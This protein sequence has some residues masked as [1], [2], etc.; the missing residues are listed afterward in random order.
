MLVTVD[1]DKRTQILLFS[2]LYSFVHSWDFDFR[3]NLQGVCNLNRILNGNYEETDAI[4]D[5]TPD[6]QALAHE[7][8]ADSAQKTN[9]MRFTSEKPLESVTPFGTRKNK[10][11]VQLTLNEPPNMQTIKVEE[12]NANSEDEII[13]RV[14][15]SKKCSLEINKSQPEP[16]CRFM[17]DR[18][19]DKV[20]M[21]LITSIIVV[22]FGKKESNL[23]SLGSV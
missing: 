17:Y 10:Y 4:L 16:G 20:L 14:Q 11:V 12:D 21:S 8:S 18:I 5:T 19:E 15:P 13:K 6:K 1:L 3:V 22:F 23:F 2:F 9:S 7:K